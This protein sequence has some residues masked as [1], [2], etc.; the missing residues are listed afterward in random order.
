MA[1][2]ME[3]TVLTHQN[4]SV[5]LATPDV[6]LQTIAVDQVLPPDVLSGAL[7]AAEVKAKLSVKDM[8]I[9]GFLA[10]AF[11][12][13]AT[14]LAVLVRTQS[15][16]FAGA[17][18]FPVGFVLLVLLGFELAT[19]NFALLPA[20]M[21]ARRVS[22]TQ[23]LRNWSWV[24]VANLAGCLAFAGL[25]YAALTNLGSIEAGP[26]GDAIT[27]TAIAKVA[28]YEALGAT[29]WL[30][31]FVKAILANWMVT[32]GVLMAFVS[33]STI[34]RI[35]AMWLP[36]MTFF[37]L[38]FEH[39]IVNMF[40]V[41]MGMLLGADVSFADWWIWNQ[42]PVTIGNIAGGALFTGLAMYATYRPKPT[43]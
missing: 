19:G 25:F 1:K 6:T 5:A 35:T 16:G 36:I 30:E 43:A 11:L 12:G 3:R 17:I 27:T 23:M 10:G 26:V 2:Q 9:R 13:F 31:A 21:A 41:P 37:A 15:V 28:P 39:S 4:G 18:I 14:A 20:G 34:G 38:G 42:I 22:G 29:G 32:V 8:L 7:A 33:R 24:F 40:V